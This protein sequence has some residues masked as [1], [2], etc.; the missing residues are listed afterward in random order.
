[1]S[2]SK[3]RLQLVFVILMTQFLFEIQDHFYDICVDILN[4]FHIFDVKDRFRYL[5]F[6]LSIFQYFL[7]HVHLNSIFVFLSVER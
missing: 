1:M 7:I 3:R 2:A 6:S 5:I 4:I